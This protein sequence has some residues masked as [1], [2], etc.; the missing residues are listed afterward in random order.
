MIGKVLASFLVVT[1]LL[2]SSAIAAVEKGD[3]EVTISLSY[4]ASE[5]Y[6]DIH[7]LTNEDYDFSFRGGYGVFLSDEIQVGLDAEFGSSEN[8][9]ASGESGRS[10]TS[11]LGNLKYHF[12]T[13]QNFVPY[14]GGQL[15]YQFSETWTPNQPDIDSSGFAYGGMFGAKWFV[16]ENLSI[17]AEYNMR[18]DQIETWSAISETRKEWIDR[19]AVFA[20]LAYYF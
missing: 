1:T 18:F 13:D 9:S 2:V 5:K 4:A 8:W 7:G 19:Y 6:I 12:F 3:Q 16:A 11:F 14:V 10:M 20:G 17:F 15:G